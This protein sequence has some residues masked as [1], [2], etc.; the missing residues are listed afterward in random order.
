MPVDHAPYQRFI[1]QDFAALPQGKF[2]ALDIAEFY[3]VLVGREPS[4]SHLFNIALLNHWSGTVTPVIAP[5]EDVIIHVQKAITKA[6]NT[7]AE[8]YRAIAALHPKL[9]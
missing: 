5:Q 6:S 3:T 1:Q 8:Y 2:A 4:S 9:E 7:I